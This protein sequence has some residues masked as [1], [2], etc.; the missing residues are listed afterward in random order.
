MMDAIPRKEFISA[1]AELSGH[2]ADEIVELTA[3]LDAVSGITSRSA[4]GE[5]YFCFVA[6]NIAHSFLT[7]T[8]AKERAAIYIEPNGTKEFMKNHGLFP[9]ESEQFL[10]DFKQ[11]LSSS[12]A[13]L[14][15]P[16]GN[17]FY[18]EVDE[19]IY[20]MDSFIDIVQKFMD[21]IYYHD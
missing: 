20:N 6:D 10:D 13:Q 12:H 14:S 9:F 3:R 4:N 16:Y 7:F 15:Y 21:T 11:Y 5:L 2:D 8:I 17:R 19:V 18:A 1:F